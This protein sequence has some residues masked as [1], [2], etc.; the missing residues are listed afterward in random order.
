MLRS[1]RPTR[2]RRSS[3]ASVDRTDVRNNWAVKRGAPG[4]FDDACRPRR[5]DATTARVG[6]VAD[7]LAGAVHLSEGEA[8]PL[9]S[10]GEAEEEG[11]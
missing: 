7:A 9:R 1:I 5:S 10:I 3:D 11:G 8:D 6:R 4:C 2:A